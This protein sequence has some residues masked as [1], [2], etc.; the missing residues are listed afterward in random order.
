MFDKKTDVVSVM[1]EI[2]RRVISKEERSVC[3][4][5]RYGGKFKELNKTEHNDT[6]ID[7]L[8]EHVR[9]YLETGYF[10]PSFTRFPWFIRKML[11]F[12]AKV[13]AR[14]TRFITREQNFV[15]QDLNNCISILMKNQQFILRELEEIEEQ[16]SALED[17]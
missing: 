6:R 7:E 8:R 10:I 11:R 2:T 4:E 3:E 13:V 9:P 1:N 12:I 5:R 15:N 16:I 14:L 17:H